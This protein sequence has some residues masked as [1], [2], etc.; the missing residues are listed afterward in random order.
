MNIEKIIFSIIGSNAHTWVRYYKVEKISGFTF[1]GE[2]IVIRSSF[3]TSNELNILF[4]NKFKV[5]NIQS[6]RIDQDSYFDI[7]FKRDLKMI[8][9]DNTLNNHRHK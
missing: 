3:L 5:E 6:K 2:Y 8:D 1:P 9:N 4:E 7:L